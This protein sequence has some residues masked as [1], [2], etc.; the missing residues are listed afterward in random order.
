MLIDFRS[1][2][3][4]QAGINFDP[5]TPK[6]DII[7]LLGSTGVESAKMASID[8]FKTDDDAYGNVWIPRTFD[9]RKKWRHCHTIG[10]VRDQGHCGSCWVGL[11]AVLLRIKI[12]SLIQHIYEFYF[13]AFGTSSAFADRLCIATN[14]D[15]NELLSAEEITFCCHTCGFGCHGGNPIKAWEYF[16]KHGLVTGGNY[17]SREVILYVVINS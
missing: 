9:A 8:Q 5:S 4:Y 10:E 7:K 1:T 11:S 6:E 15:F 2:Y 17:K 16:S 12:V 13:Q 3:V 14:A